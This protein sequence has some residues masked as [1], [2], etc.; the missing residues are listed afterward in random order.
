MRPRL[1]LF[2]AGLLVVAAA[3]AAQPSGAAVSGPVF[4]PTLT[5]VPDTVV[6][7]TPATVS[8]TTCFASNVEILLQKGTDTPLFGG[9]PP[10]NDGSWSTQIN[11]FGLVGDYRVTAACE[12]VGG[13]L[14][15]DEVVLHILPAATTTTPAPTTSAVDSTGAAGRATSRPTFTG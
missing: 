15:Y 4:D 9:V 11:T 12:A 5:L 3:V 7:G 8:G 2:V 13:D 1:A 14:V 6:A 10:N